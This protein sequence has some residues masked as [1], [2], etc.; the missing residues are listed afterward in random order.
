MMI[1][2]PHANLLK[3]FEIWV[4]SHYKSPVSIRYSD[5]A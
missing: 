2:L 3:K 5:Y 1:T 4:L